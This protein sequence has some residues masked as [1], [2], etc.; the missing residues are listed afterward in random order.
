LKVSFA[1][2]NFELRKNSEDLMKLKDAFPF[3]L[4]H[5]TCP[6]SLEDRNFSPLSGSWKLSPFF[7]GWKLSPFSGGWNE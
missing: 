2:R 4:E 3:S 7:G 6:L 5:G 1:H